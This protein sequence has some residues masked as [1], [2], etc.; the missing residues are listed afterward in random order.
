V[1]AVIVARPA[2][3]GH[4]DHQCEHEQ[5][6]IEARQDVL[7]A[8]H[9]VGRHHLEPARARFHHEPRADA[10]NTL[11]L[12]RAVGPRQAD[13]DVDPRRGQ[14]GKLYR[15]AAEPAGNAHAPA[16]RNGPGGVKAPYWR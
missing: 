9:S 14:R 4:Q 11:E 16:L 7:D 10:Q 8:E 5:Q 3:R 2:H 1:K 13:E 12:H 6:V 15:L